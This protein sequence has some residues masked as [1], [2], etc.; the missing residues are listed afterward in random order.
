MT[1]RLH[2]ER[3]VLDGVPVGTGQRHL[4]QAAVQ[5]E[6]A[7]LLGQGALAPELVGGGAMARLVAPAIA[8]PAD[9]AGVQVGG[10][11]AGAVYKA[12]GK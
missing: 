3:L 4:L 2:I 9:M 1:V 6:L 7:H 11:I 10:Q 8:L 5:A 12:I